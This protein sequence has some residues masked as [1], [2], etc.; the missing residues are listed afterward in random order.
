MRISDL[1]AY[2]QIA[3]SHSLSAASEQLHTSHQNLSKLLRQL[4]LE[5]HA[6]LCVR[7]AKGIALTEPGEIFLSFAQAIVRDYYTMQ[8]RL[9]ACEQGQ[10]ISGSF[11]LYTDFMTNGSFLEPLLQQFAEQYPQIQITTY[12]TDT[13]SVLETLSAIKT[14]AIGLAGLLTG[15]CYEHLFEP[16]STQLSYQPLQKSELYCIAN[17]NNDLAKEQTLHLYLPYWLILSNHI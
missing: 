4:E 11:N 3:Q 9:H 13:F 16:Y 7:T 6:A 5:V 1:E 15:K 8:F 12:L 14:P 10:K 2:I 17:K